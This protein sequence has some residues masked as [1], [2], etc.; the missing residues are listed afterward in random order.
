LRRAER[1]DSLNFSRTSQVIMVR[2]AAVGLAF[3]LFVAACSARNQ[4]PGNDA[5]PRPSNNVITR[6]ELVAVQVATAYEAVQR[7]RP[8][9]L[10]PRT[11][12]GA[13]PTGPGTSTPQGYAVV[14]VDGIR[15]GA[16]DHLRTIP[17]SEVAEVRL[18][19][20]M[21]AT[22]RYGMDVAGGVID[23]KLIGR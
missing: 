13:T 12:A 14:Y 8:S 9:F 5:S 15:K 10:R 4:D 21:D 6:Q 18:L 2:R 23:V 20:A 22:T 11:I 3:G 17:T 19:S 7:L 16:L 1:R